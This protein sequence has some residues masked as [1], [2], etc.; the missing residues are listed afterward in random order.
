MRNLP[1]DPEVTDPGVSTCEECM[2]QAGLLHACTSNPATSSTPSI[3]DKHMRQGCWLYSIRSFNQLETL[4]H[5]ISLTYFLK[6]Y[7]FNM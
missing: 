3:C 4:T 1:D 2:R 5:S 6:L 7:F